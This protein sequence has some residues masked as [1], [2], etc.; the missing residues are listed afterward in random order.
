[1]QDT[2]REEINPFVSDDLAATTVFAESV[3]ARFLNPFL[4]HQ[5]TSIA[6]NSI[7]KWKARNLPS[8]KDYYEAHG[9]LPAHMTVGFSYL[10]A[11]Y[12]RVEAKEN[13]WFSGNLPVMDDKPYLEYFANG[14]SVRDF[15]AKTDVWGEDL[16]AYEGFA[17]AVTENVKK[18]CAGVSLL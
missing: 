2:L 3:T 15:M 14:G 4:N 1:M 18:I 13:G 16:T 10:M 6:L 5:L 12:T 7:S 17:D 9:K 8:F 11:L